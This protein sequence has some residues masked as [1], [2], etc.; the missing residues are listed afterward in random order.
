MAS[1]SPLLL[2]KL[3]QLCSEGQREYAKAIIQKTIRLTFSLLPFAG[4]AAGAATEVVVIIYGQSFFPSG[5]LLGILIF[6]AIGVSIIVV[7]SSTLIA[8]DR[9]EWTFYL[10]LPIVVAAFGAHLML[11][12][13]FGSIGAAIVTTGLSWLGAFG[14]MLAVYRAWGIRLPVSTFLRSITICGLAYTLA[15]G[16]QTPGLLLLL[17]L[18]VISIFIIVSFT[19]LGELSSDEIS[20]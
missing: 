1:L 11:V 6:G 18:P 12:P 4:M 9:P 3:T 8:A 13:R 16:W 14:F 17:K 7:S 20:F 15:S 19:L 5:T 10:M 2:S